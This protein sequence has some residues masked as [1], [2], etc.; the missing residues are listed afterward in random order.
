[1]TEAATPVD[2]SDLASGLQ[3][4]LLDVDGVMTDGGI[5]LIGKEA[6]SKRFNVQDGVG[7]ALA[8]AAG[9]RVGIVTGRKS[10]VVQR[11]AKELNV[12]ELFQGV[13]RKVA[14][15][16]QLLEKY[17]IDAAQVAYIGDDLPDSLIMK[18]VG[19][20]IAV[21]NA[22][23]PVKDCSAHVTRAGGGHGAVREAVEW[24]LELRGDYKEACE[25]IVQ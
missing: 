7:I 12:D 21:Q 2:L 18:R 5:I 20:P 19:L 15:L 10:E 4:L 9:I 11:R 8:R 23:Q 6:E 3:M 1:V 17:G 25:K 14:V 22:V 24:L 16:E 13:G